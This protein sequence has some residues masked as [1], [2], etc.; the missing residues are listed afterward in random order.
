MKNPNVQ[1]KYLSKCPHIFVLRV[2]CNV[3]HIILNLSKRIQIFNNV[4]IEIMK[5]KKV[6]LELILKKIKITKI[7]N[8]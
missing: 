2:L 6:K 1:I 7:M 5:K 4:S 8:R 3:G